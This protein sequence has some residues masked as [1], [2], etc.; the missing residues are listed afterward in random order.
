MGFE[1]L[2]ERL[3]NPENAGQEPKAF[4][5]QLPEQIAER[6]TPAE[7]EALEKLTK[8]SDY[9]QA[10]SESHENEH[11]FFETLPEDQVQEM[12]KLNPEVIS[13]WTFVEA[14]GDQIITVPYN[15]KFTD[16]NKK[17]S[18]I[19]RSIPK[20]KQQGNYRLPPAI[21]FQTLAEGFTSN[22]WQYAEKTWLDEPWQARGV[23]FII[24]PIETHLDGY[25]GAFQAVV[26]VIDEEATREMTDTIIAASKLQHKKQISKIDVRVIHLVANAGLGL[27]LGFN[28]QALPND[29]K[30]VE[31]YGSRIVFYANLFEQTFD[32]KLLPIIQRVFEKNVVERFSNG[33]HKLL[34]SAALK[35]LAMHEESHPMNQE[36]GLEEKLGKFFNT[37]HELHCDVSALYLSSLLREHNLISSDEFEAILLTH[38][39][40]KLNDIFISEFE[41]GGKSNPYAEGSKMEFNYMASMVDFIPESGELDLERESEIIQK[42]NDLMGIFNYFAASQDVAREEIEALFKKYAEMG[43]YKFAASKLR[44]LYIKNDNSYASTV[45]VPV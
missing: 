16:L 40:R 8:V 45:S 32:E 6:L 28:A 33:S 31:K 42:I 12:A 25:K 17:V 2:T 24:G 3:K 26:G 10:L 20:I 14:K 18:E 19:L 34:R 1:K 13:K 38:F 29:P 30:M 37:F 36:P 44:D 9:V 21:R 15:Q 5:Y 27:K 35:W 41:E 43:H 7:K 23:E 39:A 22:A 4:I 11:R